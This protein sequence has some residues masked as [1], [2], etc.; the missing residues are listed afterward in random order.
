[1]TDE[2]W[3]P[4]N[5]IYKPVYP[6]QPSFIINDIAYPRLHRRRASFW[7]KQRDAALWEWQQAHLTFTVKSDVQNA[8]AP[9]EITLDL[10]DIP[11]E[12]HLAGQGCFECA[13]LHSGDEAG[14]V[15]IDIDEFSALFRSHTADARH[16][17]QYY[18]G[19]ELGHALGFGHNPDPGLMM[20]QYDGIYIPSGLELLVARRYYN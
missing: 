4:E 18:I 14:W 10:W 17:L 12:E 9:G 5:Y 16:R 7:Y 8:Y 20:A 2:S 6:D 3:Y 13:P 11:D 15:R 1:M 19:H